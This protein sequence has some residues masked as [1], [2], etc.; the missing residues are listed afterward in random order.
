MTRGILGTLLVLVGGGS[1]V[2]AQ[3]T[4]PGWPSG[5]PMAVGPTLPFGVATSTGIRSGPVTPALGFTPGFGIGATPAISPYLNLARAGNPAVNYYYGVRPWQAASAFQQAAA[6]PVPLAGFSQ[7]RGGFIPAAGTPTD[8][9]TEVPPAGEPVTLAP[10]GHPVVFGN[11]FGTLI[12][13]FPGMQTGGNR[14]GLF[15]NQPPPAFNR[16]AVSA[17]GRSNRIPTTMP[18]IP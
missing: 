1:I 7:T 3:G 8:L 16:S 14:P 11:R 15:S 17:P 12:G 2:S 4:V 5:A 6:R 13:S 9:P 18:R 10:S